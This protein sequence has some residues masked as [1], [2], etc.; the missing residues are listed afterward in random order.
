MDDDQTVYVTDVW[1]HH[2][3]AWKNG[4]E[5]GQ[6]V[7]GGNVDG[8]GAQQLNCPTDVIVDK[9][10]D[11]L[12]ICD[13][14]NNRIVRW[15]RRY[16]ASGETIIANIACFSLTM[17]GNGSLYISD[18]DNHE[19]RRYGRGE[20]QGII[21]AGG[22]GRG[23]RLDQLNSPSYIFVNR[24]QSVFVSDWKNHRVMKW[25]EGAKEGIVVAGNQGH[26][27]SLS[28]VF[29]PQGVLVD[30]LETVYVANGWNNRIIRWPKGATQGTVIAGGSGQAKQKNQ[31]NSPRDLSFDRHG[32]LYVVDQGNARV[33]RFTITMS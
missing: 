23:H 30:Q 17:D 1:N 6:V 32:H 13:R 4:M 12:I 7:A 10:T 29:Y 19:V 22:N 31:L 26:G 5:N 14:E 27:N 18:K 16:G 9:E 3:V 21:V 25:I 15:P 20:S 28:Q 8:D 11:S 24:D 33:R 2:I